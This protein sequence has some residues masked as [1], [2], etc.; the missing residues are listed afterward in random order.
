[1]ARHA[2]VLGSNGSEAFGKLRF[3]RSDAER[4]AA[5]LSAQRYSF[6]IITPSTYVD[7]YLI[8]KE[9]DTAAA[10]CAEDDSFI[11]YF[12]GHGALVGGRL[13]LVLDETVP[14]RQTT[15]LP[16]SWVQEARS[17]SVARNRLLIL[18]C[19]H[20][21]AAT[22]GKSAA[23]DVTELGIVRWTPKMRQLAKVEP[24]P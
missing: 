4:I 14:G 13:M 18:D 3:A 23:I 10:A 21:G 6:Q 8:R 11:I 9:L 17:L 16:V 7:P 5:T 20:A 22:G 19:C 2:F 12:S 15:Y 1:M 24:C